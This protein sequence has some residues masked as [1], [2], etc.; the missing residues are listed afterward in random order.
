MN[1]LC[2]SNCSGSGSLIDLSSSSVPMQNFSPHDSQVQMFRGVPQYLSRL[3]AQSTFPSSQR[4]K[5]FSPTSGGYQRIAP[6]ASISMS[7]KAVV[8]MYHERRA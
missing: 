3:R 2:R 5:R 1:G 6:L 4:A 7:L 8:R